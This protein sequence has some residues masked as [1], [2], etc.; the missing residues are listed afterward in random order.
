MQMYQVEGHEPSLLPEGKVWRYVWG[1][2]FDGD[3]LDT[4]KWSF[5]LHFWG[6]RFPAYT[7]GTARSLRRTRV[8]IT[9]SRTRQTAFTD[10]ALTG[11][12]MD[13]SFTVT[14]WKRRVQAG[15][16]RR[17]SSLSCLRRS[18]KV[19]A[20]GTWTSRPTSCGAR[21][22]PTALPLTTSACLMK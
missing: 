11:A 14:A 5:R 15:L 2:E 18:A 22:Y 20:T 21:F 10:L 13:M 6:R 17:W 12:R 16:C 8:S 9:A 4:N 7:A 3:T 19:T 1:D